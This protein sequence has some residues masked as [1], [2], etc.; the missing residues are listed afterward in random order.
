MKKQSI[1]LGGI[2]GKLRSG[3]ALFAGLAVW[4]AAGDASARE[5]VAF[6]PTYPAGTII[7]KQSERRL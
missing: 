3:S 7:I 1:S 4:I 6:S 2:I 5:F